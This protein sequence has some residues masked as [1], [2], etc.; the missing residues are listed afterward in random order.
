MILSYFGNVELIR[1]I[2][3]YQINIK[4]FYIIYTLDNST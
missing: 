3:I 1:Y 4:S 2:L